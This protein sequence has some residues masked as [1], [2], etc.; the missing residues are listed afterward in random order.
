MPADT[1]DGKSSLKFP[2]R[3]DSDLYQD[4]ECHYFKVHGLRLADGGFVDNVSDYGAAPAL[5]QQ[6]LSGQRRMRG[7]TS[8]RQSGQKNRLPSK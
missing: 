7:E 4:G 5:P 2:G 3:V 6:A 8:L 1:P